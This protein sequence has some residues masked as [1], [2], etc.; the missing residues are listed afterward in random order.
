M[1]AGV[2]QLTSDL[3]M[4]DIPDFN[5]WM[6]NEC[7][8][9]ADDAVDLGSEWDWLVFFW[10][11][12]SIGDGAGENRYTV[13]EIMNI[14]AKIAD[15][16]ANRWC[17]NYSGILD[18]IAPSSATETMPD[19]YYL[20]INGV[21]KSWEDLVEKAEFVYQNDVDKAEFFKETGRNAGVDF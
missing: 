13:K 4:V 15:Y 1:Y 10:N 17:T 11:L 2:S 8:P 7:N 9:N 16:R 18:C 5:K 21:G 20:E 12:Y 19:D 3:Y 14:W 6:E